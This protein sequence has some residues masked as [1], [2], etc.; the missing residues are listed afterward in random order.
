MARVQYI[1]AA[2]GKDDPFAASPQDIA[3]FLY[4]FISNQH[5]IS[6]ISPPARS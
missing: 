4:M 3:E 2:V 1:K 6:P 5:T